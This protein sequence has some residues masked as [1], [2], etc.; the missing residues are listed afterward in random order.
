MR[1][2][3]KNVDKAIKRL[4]KAKE[5]GE[6]IG[7]WG[8]YDPDGSCATVVMYQSLI[9]A[10]FKPENL[11]VI[12]PNAR[13]Y[14]RSFHRTFLKF[15]KKKKSSLV[16][17]IDFG[18]ADFTQVKMAKDMGFEVIILDHHLPQPG[19]LPAILVNP[20]QFK[21]SYPHKN[22]SGV[23]VTYKFLEELYKKIG[24]SLKLLEQSTD[25]VAIGMIADRIPLDRA[26]RP[27]ILKGIRQINAKKRLG[28]KILLKEAG[29][30]KA[31]IKNIR[32]VLVD[33]V[34]S[35]EGDNADNNIFRLFTTSDVI[36]ALQ[37]VKK[38]SVKVKKFHLVTKTAIKEGIKVFLRQKNLKVIFWE[39][40]PK[41]SGAVA[42]IAGGLNDYF[43]IPVFV[44]EKEGAFCK[45]SARANH[46]KN[47]DLVKAMETASRWLVSFGGHPKAAGFKLKAKN[48]AQFKKAMEQYYAKK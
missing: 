44:Y 9:H 43:K 24:V 4:L 1:I 22:W 39:Q 35:L 7:I 45:G 38:I 25:L 10:G 11:I 46:I 27:Y 41:I 19:K 20:N 23:G 3:F 30:K 16:V 48:V 13:Q 40:N 29:I 34:G 28:L 21:D 37:L 5:Q 36:T 12:L 31:V 15:L 6:K 47:A 17:G 2:K 26:N 8:D 32:E 14:Y 18:T 42:V 33:Y